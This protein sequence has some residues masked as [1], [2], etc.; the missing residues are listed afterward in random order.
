MQFVYLSILLVGIAGMTT[1]DWRYKLAY[2]QDARRTALTIL[3]AMAIFVVWDIAAIALGIFLHGQS[4]YQLQ[5]TLAPHFPVE[6]IFFLYLL[7]YCTLVTY[8]GVLA[9]RSRT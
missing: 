4:N 6:E 9:W 7:V 1:I 8:Q 5:F 2:W 3:V